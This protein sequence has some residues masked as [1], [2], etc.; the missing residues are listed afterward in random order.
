MAPPPKKPVKT[1]KKSPGRVSPRG[2]PAQQSYVSMLR[3]SSP[4]HP[5]ASS[6]ELV[7]HDAEEPV[8][9]LGG[10]EDADL[11]YDNIPPGMSSPQ[12]SFL[13]PADSAGDFSFYAPFLLKTVSSLT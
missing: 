4:R 2:T 13:F 7:L 1:N 6:S 3:A 5:L 12:S 11:D 8:A 9:Q 10:Q